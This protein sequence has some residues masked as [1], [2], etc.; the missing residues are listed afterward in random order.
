MAKN[1]DPLVRQIRQLLNSYGAMPDKTLDQ[2]G[3]A[4]D[5]QTGAY[6]FPILHNVLGMGYGANQAQG[7]DG[8]LADMLYT[9]K[10]AI[11]RAITGLRSGYRL[12]QT[13]MRSNEPYKED[14]ASNNLFRSLMDERIKA[15]MSKQDAYD[16]V[17]NAVIGELTASQAAPKVDKINNSSSSTLNPTEQE[18][19]TAKSVGANTNSPDANH[20]ITGMAQALMLNRY[21][22]RGQAEINQYGNVA[23]TLSGLVPEQLRPIYQLMADQRMQEMQNNLDL[24]HSQMASAP[25]IQMLKDAA[26]DYRTQAKSGGTG[27]S[28]ALSGLGSQNPALSSA[29]GGLGGGSGTSLGGYSG[30]GSNGPSDGLALSRDILNNLSLGQEY[31]KRFSS[32]ENPVVSNNQVTYLRD[33][34]PRSNK[35]TSLVPQ[36]MAYLGQG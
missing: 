24:T 26:S 15:G 17:K 13:H 25:Y 1:I 21:Y 16:S 29:L 23:Q 7:W 8:G 5:Q 9:D 31:G 30:Y 10:D 4:K 36:I 14:S 27:A 35:A 22:D 32:W 3:S 11:G 18:T 6:S 20:D 34:I 28:S 19:L 2:S 33:F 12:G